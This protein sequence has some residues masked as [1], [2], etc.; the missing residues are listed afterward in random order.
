MADHEGLTSHPPASSRREIAPLAGLAGAAAALL[1][2][3]AATGSMPAFDRAILLALRDGADPADPLGP[4]WL[5]IAARDLTSLGSIAVLVLLSA[6]AAVFLAIAG[7]RGGA[8]L[9]VIAVGGG[10]ILSTVLKNLFDRARPDLV[11]HAVEV[12][13]PSFPSGHAMLSAVVYLTLG[14]LLTRFDGSGRAKAGVMAAALGLV[15]LVGS[16]RVYLG[17][18]WPT[19]VLAGW[20]FGAAWALVCWLAARRL[21][22]MGAVEK[23]ASPGGA[24]D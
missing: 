15:L 23:E 4:L 16:S 3:L 12:Y 13:T 22:R 21:Q 6:L 9:I 19:D 11:P 10:M 7:K 8:P 17:V 14:A 20:C 1:L 5:E 24:A 18:H 2:L